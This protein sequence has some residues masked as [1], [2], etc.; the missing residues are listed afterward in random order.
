MDQRLQNCM[1]GHARTCSAPLVIF[2]SIFVI[3]IAF[4]L[5]NGR[6]RAL[7]H[8]HDEPSRARETDLNKKSPGFLGEGDLWTWRKGLG[9]RPGLD[10]I[11]VII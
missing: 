1:D 11:A 9:Y 2:V 5:R 3:P 10:V 6:K 8:Q 4:H 7:E